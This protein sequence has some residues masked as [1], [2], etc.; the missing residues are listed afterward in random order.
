M[1]AVLTRRMCIAV[2]F[3]MPWFL[4]LGRIST[5]IALS[6]NGKIAYNLCCSCDFIIVLCFIYGRSENHEVFSF[7]DE[8]PPSPLTL[9]VLAYCILA[10]V[11]NSAT[12]VSIAPECPFLPKVSSQCTFVRPPKLKGRFLFQPAHN[13]QWGYPWFAC[14]QTV[15]MI[16]IYL[17]RLKGKV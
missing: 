14:Y 11:A 16:L 8:T 2:A 12:K 17:Y 7:V 6:Q 5:W 13:C 4:S 1:L 9:N 15:H 3:G 10:C